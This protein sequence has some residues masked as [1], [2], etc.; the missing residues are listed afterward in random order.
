MGPA[1]LAPIIYVLDEFRALW[2]EPEQAVCQG[3][4]RLRSLYTRVSS[5]RSVEVAA[6]WRF[7]KGCVRCSQRHYIIINFVLNRTEHPLSMLHVPCHAL[8]ILRPLTHAPGNWIWILDVIAS[9]HML[10]RFIPRLMFW[11]ETKA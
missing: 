8:C 2:G 5:C 4:L 7:L 1:A 3:Q 10:F 9:A 11:N 6:A